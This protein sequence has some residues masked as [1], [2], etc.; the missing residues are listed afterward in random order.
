LVLPSSFAE[1]ATTTFLRSLP[2]PKSVTPHGEII[3]YCFDLK[4]SGG[5]SCA[6]VPGQELSDDRNLN[7]GRNPFLANAR[8]APIRSRFAA[9]IVWKSNNVTPVCAGL[10]RPHEKTSRSEE[11]RGK[12]QT[13][14]GE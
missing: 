12:Y 4:P 8:N 14:C 9:A 7:G 6:C 5:R 11:S 13:N 10:D 1:A 2:L 3:G